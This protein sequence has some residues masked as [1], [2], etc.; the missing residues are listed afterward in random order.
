MEKVTRVKKTA[1]NEL[2]ESENYKVDFAKLRKI[3]PGGKDVIPV[4]VQDRFTLEVLMIGYADKTA[5]DYTLKN[6]RAAFWSTS[7]N[8]LWVKGKTSGS[9]IEVFEVRVNCEQNSLLYLAKPLVSGICHTK[10]KGSYRKTCFY[11]RI[12]SK[13]QKHNLE[14]I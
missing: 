10:D 4:V 12:N 13:G 7:R 8:E 9:E 3:Q 14:F 5:L 2:E 11:R 6:K 1:E